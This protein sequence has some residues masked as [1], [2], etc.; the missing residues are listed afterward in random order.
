MS[1]CCAYG[2]KNEKL[3]SECR[4]KTFFRF[5]FKDPLLVKKWL[6]KIRRKDFFPS[7]SSTICSDHFEESCFTYQP[8]T[9]RRQLKPGSV[10]TI[11]VYSIPPISER[12]F[13]KRKRQSPKQEYVHSNRTSPIITHCHP[14][15]ISPTIHYVQPN[16]TSSTV[17]YV[18][19]DRTS[20]TIHYIKS[21]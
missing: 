17:D 2:C 4:N 13:K 15:R 8:F 1:Y 5:P 10:P 14:D 11:F 12:M 6:V 3:K 21:N 7:T 16:R 18:Y 9:N 19:P 20:P